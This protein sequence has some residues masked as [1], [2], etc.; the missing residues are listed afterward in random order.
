MLI[1]FKFLFPAWVIENISTRQ[2][3]IKNNFSSC[4][5]SQGLFLYQPSLIKPVSNVNP[6]LISPH[7]HINK[8]FFTPWASHWETHGPTAAAAVAAAVWWVFCVARPRAHRSSRGPP[9]ITLAR[10]HLGPPTTPGWDFL[11]P[12]RR[13]FNLDFVMSVLPDL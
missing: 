11:P 6:P 1:L 10:W 5:Q 13:D 8:M 4:L 12:L 9:Y 3:Q 7:Y 2:E